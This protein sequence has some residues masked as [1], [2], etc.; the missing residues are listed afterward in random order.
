M[1][2]AKKSSN[3]WVCV[4]C[5]QKQSIR[6]VFAEGFMAKNI[7]QYV[8]KFNMSRQSSDQKELPLE[9]G[10]DTFEEEGFSAKE[11]QEKKR[12]DWAEYV[13]Y[14]QD[15]CS[16]RFE[17]CECKRCLYRYV[18]QSLIPIALVTR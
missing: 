7:R 15:D 13:E 1:K 17:K 18:N 9:E 11:D 8:Q 14:D 4:V 5:N 12:T 16:K 3:K 6:R 2:Q 10:D